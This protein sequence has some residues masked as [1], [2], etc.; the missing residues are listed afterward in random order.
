MIQA[1]AVVPMLAPMMTEIACVS[2]SKPALTKLTV[3]TVVAV[4][5]W[6]DVV[7]NAPVKRPVKRLVVILPRTWRNLLPAIFCN[8]S[9]I[10]FIP[11]MSK[12]TEPAR[13]NN[14]K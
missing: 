6:I 12:A 2:V 10:T 13:T 11:Y 14:G 5:D 3:M 1:V 9:L 8:P 4:E 7:M